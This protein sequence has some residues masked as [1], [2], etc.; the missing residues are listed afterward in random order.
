MAAM[1]SFDADGMAEISERASTQ[2]R[3]AAPSLPR[4]MGVVNASPRARASVAAARARQGEAAGE[5]RAEEHNYK[6]HRLR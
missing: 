5:G 4:P 3:P 6:L 1:P 2:T